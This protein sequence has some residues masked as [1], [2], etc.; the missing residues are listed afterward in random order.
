MSEPVPAMRE[1]ALPFPGRRVEY[2]TEMGHHI[3]YEFREYLG[4]GFV[5][6]WRQFIPKG[7]LVPESQVRA[8]LEY[9]FRAY[10]EGYR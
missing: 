1:R 9:E 8:H 2:R 10:L 3:A 5:A 7:A 4:D 6:S